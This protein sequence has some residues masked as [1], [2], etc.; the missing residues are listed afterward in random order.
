MSQVAD[1]VND[2]LPDEDAL[3]ERGLHDCHEVYVADDYVSLIFRRSAFSINNAY[4]EELDESDFFE[5]SEGN[6]DSE[7][8]EELRRY[9]FKPGVD[10]I[11]ADCIKEIVLSQVEVSP[12]VLSR[13]EFYV[14]I[15]GSGD[16]D[17]VEMAIHFNGDDFQN[18]EL[19][20][21]S[22]FI[23]D[24]VATFYNMDDRGTYNYPYLYDNVRRVMVEKGMI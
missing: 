22:G 19:E 13:M 24:F 4:F 14:D 18:V 12:Q 2:N 9:E 11:M 1:F 23:W 3:V 8:D 15:P 17:M 16:I 10:D 6:V 5:V 20:K 21:F 7:W